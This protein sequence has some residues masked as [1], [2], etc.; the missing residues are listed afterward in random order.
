MVLFVAM[1]QISSD[2][3]SPED[4]AHTPGDIEEVHGTH[5]CGNLNT[6]HQTLD[7]DNSDARRCKPN[8]GHE[9]TSYSSPGE[10]RL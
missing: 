6:S 7:F 9:H 10:D 2:L 3:F 5:S 1:I 4:D 8:G